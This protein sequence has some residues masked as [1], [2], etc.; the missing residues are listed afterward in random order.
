MNIDTTV[1]EKNITFPTDAKLHKKIIRQ[2]L[3]IAADEQ[4]PVRQTYTRTLKKLA[5]D[6]RFRNQPRNKA[7]RGTQTVESKLLQEDWCVNWSVIYLR[8]QS[9]KLL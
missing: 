9:I 5:L 8:T 4:L 1:Q 6:Q 2:C 7:K 3:Q